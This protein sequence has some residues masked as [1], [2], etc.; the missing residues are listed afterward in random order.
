MVLANTIRIKNIPNSV[1]LQE[2]NYLY[3]CILDFSNTN[4]HLYFS[5]I[6]NKICVENKYICFIPFLNF[7]LKYT[8]LSVQPV[9]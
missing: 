3:F 9:T 7:I 5:I 1:K 6:I 4:L 2:N 8:H